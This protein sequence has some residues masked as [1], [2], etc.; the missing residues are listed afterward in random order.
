MADRFTPRVE[1]IFK[2]ARASAEKR[3][4]DYIGTED[5][6][7]GLLEEGEG[8]GAIA[9]KTFVSLDKVKEAVEK[10]P[11]MPGPPGTVVAGHSFSPRAK[12]VIELGWEASR[13]LGQDLIATEHIL[14][15]LLKDHDSLAYEILEKLEVE[16]AKVRDKIL[17]LL[18]SD[19]S[20]APEPQKASPA[21][22]V[23]CHHEKLNF[24]SG[25]FFIVCSSCGLYWIAVDKHGAFQPDRGSAGLTAN[26]LRIK[27]N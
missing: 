24:A 16:P 9:L 19:V 23:S 4:Y 7:L 25:G 12:S 17:E 18:G 15:G 1:K 11:N 22:N 8:L 5:L 14:F 21:V 10:L 13:T 20:Q 2:L 27:K 26:D 3:K 6:L